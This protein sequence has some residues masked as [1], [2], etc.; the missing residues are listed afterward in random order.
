M[1]YGLDLHNGRTAGSV[2]LVGARVRDLEAMAAGRHQSLW[3][4]DIGDNSHRRGTV[5][6]FNVPVPRRGPRWVRPD[7]VRLRYPDGRHNAEA[8]IVNRRSGA[9]WIIT[10]D[11]V[12]HVYRVPPHAGSHGTA[13]MRRLPGVST[14]AYVTD[15]VVL[16]GGRTALL[17]NYGVAGIYRLPSWRQI[18]LFRLPWQRR[19]RP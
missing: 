8:M 16:A 7:S 12:G 13:T 17:R 5:H 19:V 2:H 4:G 9:K 11:K 10:K 14:Q 1:V 6:L 3:L 15:G 18:G